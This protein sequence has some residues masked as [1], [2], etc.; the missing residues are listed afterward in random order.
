VGVGKK[1][2]FEQEGWVDGRTATFVVFM[3]GQEDVKIE[4]IVDDMI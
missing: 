1:D 4:F 2:D 3:S